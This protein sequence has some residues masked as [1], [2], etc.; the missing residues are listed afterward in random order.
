VKKNTIYLL[1]SINIVMLLSFLT[2]VFY[3]F[4][5]KDHPIKIIEAEEIVI[6]HPDSK[7]TISL[8]V[9]VSGPEISINDEKGRAKIY[10]NGSGLYLK[11]GSDKIIGS[12]T[13]LADGGG[14]FGLADKEGM[15]S[16]IIR[17][18]DNP[19]L[20]LFGNKADPI[21]AFG[22]MQNVP[23]LIVSAQTGNE[24]ILLHGGKRS[25]LMVL[26]ESG[27]LKIFICKDGIFQGKQETWFNEPPEKHKYFTHK[28]DKAILF[29]DADKKNLR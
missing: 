8:K 17:G 25:G 12:F 2:F 10:F 28:E 14:G 27:Q 29:P 6:K 11:N 23:H 19:S 16:S 20:S 4:K 13:T 7:A 15:A 18:G 24:G 1:L 21:A 9:D 22:I 26:D 5:G 3:G